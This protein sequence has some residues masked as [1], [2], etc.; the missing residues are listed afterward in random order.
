MKNILAENMLRFGSKNLTQENRENLKRLTEDFVH[1]G[2]TYK[3][4]FKNDAAFKAYILS[5]D[6]MGKKKNVVDPYIGVD[7]DVST[8]PYD[9]GADEDQIKKADKRV[10]KI[11]HWHNNIN[12]M[13]TCYWIGCAVYGK[14]PAGVSLASFMFYIKP[15][16]LAIDTE[17]G[18]SPNSKYTQA[19]NFLQ[20]YADIFEKQY[21]DP[22]DPTKTKKIK[23]IDW[24]NTYIYKPEYAIKS[25]IALPATAV[26]TPKPVK[27][28]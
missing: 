13:L 18:T 7:T 20:T 10:A 26:V 23:Y 3:L 27:K 14:I 5:N 19:T 21:T 28:N 9:P 8:S 16:K 12:N 1:N 15:A 11:L 25:K 24:F 22:A 17:L 2:I 4:N 6:V